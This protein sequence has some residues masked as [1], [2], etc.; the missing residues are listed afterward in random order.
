MISARQ[1]FLL[2]TLL[3]K[4]RAVEVNFLCE[5][6]S[7]SERTLKEEIRGINHFLEPYNLEVK[8][9]VDNKYYVEEDKKVQLSR[10]LKE[11]ENLCQWFPETPAQRQFFELFLLLWESRPISMD[12]ISEKILVSRSCVF[13]DIKQLN[14]F[15]KQ[16]RK[17]V[18]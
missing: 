9:S 8:L 6:L 4:A 5:T 14:E 12:E 13:H 1:E 17:S 15:V 18:G 16:D 11:Y 7:I 3:N 2:I 10:V